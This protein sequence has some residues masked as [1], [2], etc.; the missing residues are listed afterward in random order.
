MTAALLL[1]VTACTQASSPST[2][3]P[4][5]TKASSALTTAPAPTTPQRTTATPAPTTP[6][7]RTTVNTIR[8]TIDGAPVDVTLND[9]AAARDFAEQLPLNLTLTDFHGTEKIADLSRRLSTSGAPAGA[10]PRVGDLAY[11]APWGNLAIY[12]RDASYAYGVIILGH[13]P[14]SVTEQLAATDT[15]AVT[16]E[17]AS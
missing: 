4:Q 8:L 5:R 15:A 13:V 3:T 16:I 6:S 9:S 12:Y 10:D 7:G 2:K 17:P 1:S 11:Y 14:E